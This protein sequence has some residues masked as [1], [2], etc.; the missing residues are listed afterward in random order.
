MWRIRVQVSNG[1]RCVIGES[2]VKLAGSSPDTPPPL[3]DL[4]DFVEAAAAAVRDSFLS[5][6]SGSSTR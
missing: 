5:K 6:L 3:Q 1:T 2:L 4:L